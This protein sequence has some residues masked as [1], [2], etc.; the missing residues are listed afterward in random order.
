MKSQH[1]RGTKAWPKEKAGTPANVFRDS[2][3]DA[4]KNHI[5]VTCSLL[6]HKVI[7]TFLPKMWDTHYSVWLGCSHISCRWWQY[8]PENAC[9]PT[10]WCTTQLYVKCLLCLWN[11]VL[12]VALESSSKLKSTVFKQIIVNYHYF[13]MQAVQFSYACQGASVFVT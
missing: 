4:G 13:K 5:P 6:P 11:T 9:I 1:I 7:W 10:T 2:F 3:Y 8:T 12:W